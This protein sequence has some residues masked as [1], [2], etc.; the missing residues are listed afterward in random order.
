MTL[1]NH[2]KINKQN[3]TFKYYKR[4]LTFDLP[5]LYSP[6][7]PVPTFSRLFFNLLNP[8]PGGLFKCGSVRIR[9]RNTGNNMKHHLLQ[10]LLFAPVQDAGLP[11]GLL[12][13]LQLLGLLLYL[14]LQLLVLLRPVHQHPGHTLPNRLLNVGCVNLFIFI[15]SLKFFYRFQS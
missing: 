2:L 13:L 6:H 8:D 4:I 14:Q 9:I 10:F 11:V 12:L 7:E 15:S 1:K 3:I 5:V